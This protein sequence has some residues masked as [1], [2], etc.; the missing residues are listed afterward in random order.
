MPQQIDENIGS[1]ATTQIPKD[2]VYSAKREPLSV[3]PLGFIDF[4]SKCKIKYITADARDEKILQYSLVKMLPFLDPSNETRMREL[5]YSPYKLILLE[6]G[7]VI[8]SNDYDYDTVVRY[9]DDKDFL[10]KMGGDYFAKYMIQSDRAY[11]YDARNKS[12]FEISDRDALT[13]PST[14]KDVNGDIQ[15]EEPGLVPLYETEMSILEESEYLLPPKYEGDIVSYVESGH[16]QQDNATGVPKQRIENDYGEDGLWYNYNG[17]G[18]TDEDIMTHLKYEATRDEE[19]WEIDDE[20]A[21]DEWKAKY[22]SLSD[23][24]KMIYEEKKEEGLEEDEIYEFLQQL[25]IK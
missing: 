23:V 7:N 9:T 21:F 5:V 10:A 13:T 4:D 16:W 15:Q 24:E 11:I 2:G 6:D 8:M 19:W 18:F 14:F 3:I 1:Q 22:D 20:K 25:S 12:C 17:R